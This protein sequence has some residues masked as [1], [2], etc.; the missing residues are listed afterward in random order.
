MGV[1]AFVLRIGSTKADW[2]S[3]KQM[4]SK[5]LQPKKCSV[6]SNGSL[7]KSKCTRGSL[8]SWSHCS[9]DGVTVTKIN[10][11]VLTTLL[12][13]PIA[14]P[15]LPGG[16]SIKERCSRKLAEFHRQNDQASLK[17]ARC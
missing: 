6:R 15:H 8:R 1:S 16:I 2:K 9:G 3:S 10:T 5:Q 13:L 4:L 11:G 12:V 17:G 7:R 14:P